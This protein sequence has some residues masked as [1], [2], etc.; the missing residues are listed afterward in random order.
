MNAHLDQAY[1]RPLGEGS[2]DRTTIRSALRREQAKR[3]AERARARAI[4]RR[5]KEKAEKQT[6][7]FREDHAR[8]LNDPRVLA[9][10][11]ANGAV[12]DGRWPI[13]FN[14]GGPT[15]Y[16]PSVPGYEFRDKKY[17]E[18][19]NNKANVG[20]PGW[21]PVPWDYTSDKQYNV[22]PW[23]DDGALTANDARWGWGYVAGMV[24]PPLKWAYDYTF[25][26][27]EAG[28]PIT[29]TFEDDAA[30]GPWPG[31]ALQVTVPQYKLSYSDY[32]KYLSKVRNWLENR[33][34]YGSDEAAGQWP[35]DAL[36]L[37]IPQYKFPTLEAYAKFTAEVH[38]YLGKAAHTNSLKLGESRYE[39]SVPEGLEFLDRDWWAW[40]DNLYNAGQPGWTPTPWN[41]TSNQPYTTEPWIRAPYDDQKDME[42][43]GARIWGGALELSTSAATSVLGGQLPFKLTAPGWMSRAIERSAVDNFVFRSIAQDAEHLG[44][45]NTALRTVAANPESIYAMTLGRQITKI[46]ARVAFNEVNSEFFKLRGIKG[47]GTYNT[48]HWNSLARFPEMAVDPR[49]LFLVNTAV[50]DGSRIGEHIFLHWITRS[51][52]PYTGALRPGAL[53]NLGPP[54]SVIQ[55]LP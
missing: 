15:F 32:G 51:G 6:R 3:E 52:N 17:W 24:A 43:L 42:A 9:S 23:V 35:G 27:A 5:D 39:R 33:D 28:E 26:G 1:G 47:L 46:E 12:I 30:V 19:R 11:A 2:D 36:N 45:W 34:Y 49:N 48:H 25:S 4:A 50:N 29:F 37:P 54:R 18:W 31:N 21:E 16:K 22:E 55:P 7:A 10:A 13:E 38:D 14:I 40:R 20:Q 41:R 8:L 53:L 44:Q